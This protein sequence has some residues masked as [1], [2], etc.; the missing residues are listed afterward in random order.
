M[1]KGK[2]LLCETS[3]FE[4]QITIK[5]LKR[6]KIVGTDQISAQLIQVGCNTL[7]SEIHRLINSISN[8][9]EVPQ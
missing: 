4:V 9:E 1:H 7:C 6:Y 8:K 3:C 5:K 2:L